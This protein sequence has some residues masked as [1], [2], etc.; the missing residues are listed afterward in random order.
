MYEKFIFVLDD[1]VNLI[2]YRGEVYDIIWYFIIEVIIL[3]VCIRME[4]FE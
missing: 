4:K 1:I 2:Y 3:C